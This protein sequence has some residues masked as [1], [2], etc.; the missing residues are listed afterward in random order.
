MSAPCRG[1]GLHH[2]SIAA[3]WIIRALRS[4]ESKGGLEAR[5]LDEMIAPEIVAPA[6]GCPGGAGLHPGQKSLLGLLGFLCLLRLFRLLRFLSHSIL[7]WVNGWKRDTR[8][9]RRR[10]SLATSSKPIPTDSRGDAPHCHACVIALSTVVMRF[11]AFS[12]ESLP[13]TRCG[14]IPVRVKKTR[15]TKKQSL[16]SDSI[17]TEGLACVARVSGSLTLTRRRARKP[18]RR[19]GGYASAGTLRRIARPSRFINSKPQQGLR[20][21]R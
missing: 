18:R 15:Q 13:R 7:I 21:S 11:G 19:V 14:W 10:A 8:H 6:I 12:R 2:T 16:R 17:G 4:P 5:R 3:R 20:L 1:G 9:A